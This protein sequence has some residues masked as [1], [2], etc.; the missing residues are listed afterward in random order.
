MWTSGRSNP[1]GSSEEEIPTQDFVMAHFNEVISFLITAAL[2]WMG[3]TLFD[4]IQEQKALRKGVKAML[5][6]R[7]Y[8]SARYY[9]GQ[10]G[11]DVEGLENL[12]IVY[13]AYHE[14]HGNGTG[15]TLYNKVKALPVREE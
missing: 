14:L 2:G 15:T 7:L 12:G 8:Q 1:D 11:V 5:H 4:T 6:D 3:K 10:G 13:E 9:L